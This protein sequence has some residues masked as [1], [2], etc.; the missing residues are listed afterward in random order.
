MKQ[1]RVQ[2]IGKRKQAPL[3]SVNPEGP[4]ARGMSTFSNYQRL[5]DSLRHRQ[6]VIELPSRRR[7]NGPTGD[8]MGR[9]PVNEALNSGDQG[10]RLDGQ[11]PGPGILV[12]TSTL[13]LLS[14]NTRAWE[15]NRRIILAQSGSLA[16][17]VLPAAVTELC[18]EIKKMLESRTEPKDWEQVEVKRLA[19]D[20]ERPVLLRGF[21]LPDWGGQQT[22]ILVVME[23]PHQLD[24]AAIGLAMHRFQLT[25][26]EQNVIEHLAKGWTNKEIAHTLG[27]AEQTVKEHFKR[28][29]GKTNTTTRTGLLVRLFLSPGNA[30][31]PR[32]PQLEFVEECELIDSTSRL[33][34]MIALDS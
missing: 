3:G 34:S 8:K 25:P 11:R 30:D 19:G 22:C 10:E 31:Y 21:G 27:I 26:R 28:L 23:E 1:R 18:G 2:R 24:R 15:Q 29:L 16:G 4:E 13:Q 9:K 14:M 17:G 32:R 5:V 7:A 20:V 33:S 6:K 12:L